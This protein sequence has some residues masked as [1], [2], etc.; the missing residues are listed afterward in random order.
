[1]H[2]KHNR[3]RK[4]KK[5]MRLYNGGIWPFSKNTNTNNNTTTTTNNSQDINTSSNNATIFFTDKISIQSMPNNYKS[6]GIIHITE[7]SG[8]NVLRG[9]G[10]DVANIFGNKGF[11]NSVYDHLR[12]ITFDKVNSTL[13]NK[14]KVFN[15]RLDFGTNPQGT[16]IFLNLYGDLCEP[17]TKK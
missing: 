4:L 17:N 12:K 14:Q 1:M 11:D 3:S 2:T 7:S 8:I 16:T 6:V 9:I 10:T 5:T 13:N 15:T